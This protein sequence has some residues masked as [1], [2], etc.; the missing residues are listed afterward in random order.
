MNF[1]TV[2]QIKKYLLP[3]IL[4]AGTMGFAGCQ[5][6]PPEPEIITLSD[7]ETEQDAAQ[8]EE[9]VS[10]TL[11]EGLDV[12]L[13]A[14][15][16]LLGDPIALDMDHQG[17]ALITKT[18]RSR[19]SEFDIRDVDPGWYQ[20]TIKFQSVEDRR[21]FLHRVLTPERSDENTFVPD[22]NEDGI[23]DWRDLTVLK[24]EVWRIEDTSGNNRANRSQLF[25][26][27]FHDEV[28][29]VAGAVL[30]HEGEVFVGVGPD[31]WRLRDTNNDGMAD[32]KESISHGYN[33]HIGF[34]GHGMSGLTVGPDGRIYWGI[35]DMG[36]NIV[37]KEGQHWNYPNRGVIVRSDPDGSN[38]E[39]FAHGVRNTHEFTFDKYGNLI[40]VD[41]DGDHA[42]E[43][44]RLVYLINGSDSG[45][46][47]NWQFGKYTDPKNNEYKVWMD[48]EYY[49][50]RFEN[51]AAHILPPIA[52]YH[53]GPAGMAYNPGTALNENWKDH[54]FIMSFRGSVSN[55]PIYAF[56]LKENGASFELESEQEF[57]QGIL[58]VGID[59]GPDGALYL[60]DWLQGWGTKNAGRIWKLDDPES[61][62]SQIRVETRNL[63]GEDFSGYSAGDLTGL[64]GHEDMR[65]RQKAQ[66]K[67]V[68]RDDRWSLLSAIESRDRQLA[69]VHGIWGLAQLGRRDLDAVE[70]LTGFLEDSD[71]EI[72]A[73]AAKMLGNVKYEPAAE[74]L[75]PLLDD[76]FPRAQFFATEALGRIGY[77]PA[78]DPIVEMLEENNDEDV[79]LRHGGAIALARIGDGEAVASL[80]DHPS[81]AVRIAA[82]VA[83]KR[84]GHPEIVR[85]LE[86][87]DEFIVTNAARAISDDEY[88]EEA[89]PALAR[90]L[91]QNLFVNEPLMRRAINANLYVGDREAAERLVEFALRQVMDEDLRVEAL[92]TLANWSD[93]SEYDRVTGRH[94]GQI[95]ND[96]EEA[97]EALSPAAGEL[98]AEGSSTIKVALAEALSGLNDTSSMPALYELLNSDS[99][100]E[101]RIAALRGLKELQYNE[102]DEAIRIALDDSEISVRMSAL[103][104]IPDLDLPEQTITELLVTVL[105]EGSVN[106]Q[107]TVLET[108]GGMEGE[109]AASALEDALDPLIAGELR[110]E[111]QLDLIQ[112]VENL[113]NP[114]L[115]QRLEQYEEGKSKE[116][117][118]E[119][120]RES[121][122][123][124]D[125]NNGRRIFY[126]NPAAQCVRCHAVD[127]RGADVGPDLAGIGSRLSRE[128]LLLSLVDP[129]AQLSPGFSV[130]S[131]TLSDGET[132]NGT[133]R[134]E[135]ETSITLSANGEERTLQKS[136]IMDRVNAPSAMPQMGNQ[137]S[138]GELRDL[139]EFLT[140]LR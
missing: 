79:Y 39:V 93:P 82:V 35:G 108:L 40:T 78:L 56:T 87:E 7:E 83:M 3:L 22:N 31:M 111:I 9:E 120:F 102:M 18:N 51:Q 123:G 37:D 62:D 20:E 96:A 117:P 95:H 63:L 107:Q 58:A 92:N 101:V 88:V 109:A 90:M 27:D 138:R 75:I 33:V 67:L 12:S 103:S 119:Q 26:K 136:N 49:Q 115:A 52:P 105:E 19:N 132:V 124:G 28:T 14:S 71:P 21:D 29:D 73:Q 42:G 81:R 11:P 100:A 106:E 85:F 116:D 72:R 74:A 112:A 77:R 80:A 140:T 36:I 50:P 34:S 59:F 129:S 94:R 104:M 5:E 118:V 127:G 41:N 25:T 139:V 126:Q 131:L 8:I 86:D 84:L 55:S 45:W 15:E 98:I 57:L 13:W 128:E 54:F 60:A 10:V 17:R 134:S 53:S 1:L 30:Y 69:R 47:T 2:I 4:I 130:M 89:L 23:H 44:E 70:P 135:T 46:R 99:S 133:F 110:P 48:E 137:L 66:F 64:L 122:R 65:V 125:V 114:A 97:K 121:L 24:E 61:A 113:N 68:G 43:H 38:F 32:W 6:A 16:K 76:E 91:D